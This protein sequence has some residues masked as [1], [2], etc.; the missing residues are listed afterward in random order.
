MLHL[1]KTMTDSEI[2]QPTNGRTTQGTRTEYHQT[3]TKRAE[4][5]EQDL[6]QSGVKRWATLAMYNYR[7]LHDGAYGSVGMEAVV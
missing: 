3:T 1:N 7:V 5:E 2:L 4:T 6:D